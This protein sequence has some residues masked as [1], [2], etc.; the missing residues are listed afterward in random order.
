MGPEGNRLALGHPCLCSLATCSPKEES[1][2]LPQ[3][4]KSASDWLSSSPENQLIGTLRLDL[5]FLNS[6]P[7]GLKQELIVNLLVW[8]LPR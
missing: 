2:L 3:K 5:D 6:S 1:F 4:L 7:P 8:G